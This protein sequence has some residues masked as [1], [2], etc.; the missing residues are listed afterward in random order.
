MFASRLPSN[1]G[2]DHGLRVLAPTWTPQALSPVQFICLSD[3]LHPEKPFLAFVIYFKTHGA[4]LLD[5][6]IEMLGGQVSSLTT[7][8]LKL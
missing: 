4:S 7:R 3:S 1:R 6:N 8:F 5:K 2:R